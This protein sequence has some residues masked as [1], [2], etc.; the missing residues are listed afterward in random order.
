[1]SVEINVETAKLL[2]NISFNEIVNKYWV[3]YYSGEP[4]NKWKLIEKKDMCLSFCEYKAP[5]LIDIKNWIEKEYGY[6]IISSPIIGEITNG[7]YPFIGWESDILITKE[8]ED[9]KYKGYPVLK[10]ITMYDKFRG[11]L[12]INRFDTENESIEYGLQKAL[13]IIINE[14]V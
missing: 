2:K 12:N 13:E 1:M 4:Y 8:P 11:D 6:Y 10:F 5:L 7:Y 3:N 14:V 9:T